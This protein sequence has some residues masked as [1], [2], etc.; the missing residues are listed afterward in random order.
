MSDKKILVVDDEKAILNL[1][2]QVFTK[3][4]YLVRTAES[5]GDALE[6]LDNETI[7]VIFSDLNMPEM[8]GIEFCRAVK[9]DMPMSIVYAVT[10]YASLFELAECREAGFEDYFKKPVNIA[11]LLKKA[12][13]A[14][15]KLDRW[16]N[17]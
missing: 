7:S 9:K 8:N 16:K 14:F 10:G 3:A 13:S 4:G 17:S 2:S 12:E 6:I 5:A 11:V 15:E 1:L